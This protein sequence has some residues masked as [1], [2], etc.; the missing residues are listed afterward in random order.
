MNG[1]RTGTCSTAKL[2]PSV[3]E[4]AVADVGR[5]RRAWRPRTLCPQPIIMSGLQDPGFRY[6]GFRY[7]RQRVMVEPHFV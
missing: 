4:L 1:G 7:Q 6:P 5:R 3:D 2:P